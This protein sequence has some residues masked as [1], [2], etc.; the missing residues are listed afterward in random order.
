MPD[1]LMYQ[2]DMFVVLV[3]GEAEIFLTPDEL[4]DRLKS[5]LA[6][7]QDDLPRDL[8]RSLGLFQCL[9]CRTI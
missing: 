2:G 7:R 4:L 1:A 8:Q 5:L 6:A 3:P 9:A